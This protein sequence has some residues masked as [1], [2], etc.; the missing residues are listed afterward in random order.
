MKISFLL[1]LMLFTQNISAQ[2]AEKKQIIN[3]LDKQYDK[4]V[5][6]AQNIWNY[7]EVAFLESKSSDLLQKEL[8]NAG[9][10]VLRFA[11]FTS[12][13]FNFREC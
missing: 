13:R 9:F 3:N 10:V 7:A 1:F 6:V 5:Q 2:D 4:Y 8:K 12:V 11:G